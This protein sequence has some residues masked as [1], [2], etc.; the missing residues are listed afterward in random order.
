MKNIPDDKL[1]ELQAKSA[2]LYSWFMQN[3]G[4]F[5]ALIMDSTGVYIMGNKMFIPLRYFEESEEERT[6]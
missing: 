1:S 5:S 3:Y 6:D 4:L 2:E